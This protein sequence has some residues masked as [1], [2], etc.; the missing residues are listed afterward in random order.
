MILVV[1]VHLVFLQPVSM[2]L[3]NL[4]Q[5]NLCV[6]FVVLVDILPTQLVVSLA[7]PATNVL[8]NLL[9]FLVLL[10]SLLLAAQLA[11]T[12]VTVRVSTLAKLLLPALMP[13]KVLISTAITLKLFHVP[14]VLIALL[15]LSILVLQVVIALLP[16]AHFATNVI[17]TSTKTLLAPPLAISVLKVHTPVLLALLSAVLAYALAIS[18]MVIH[19]IFVKL[20]SDVQVT[21]RPILVTA[22]CS[23]LPKDLHHAITVALV[24]FPTMLTLVVAL[25]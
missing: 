23:T 25:A 9:R 3:I 13:L 16:V 17:I 14:L 8:V 10:V 18:S 6:L 1:N 12:Y 15:V 22:I 21:L 19:A 2:V 7:L 20:V 4:N 5:L 11:V 24:M